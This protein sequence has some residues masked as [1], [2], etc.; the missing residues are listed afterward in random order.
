MIAKVIKIYVVTSTGWKNYKVNSLSTREWW[1]YLKKKKHNM[2]EN[3]PA[4]DA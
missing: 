1:F 2:K 4:S 3:S